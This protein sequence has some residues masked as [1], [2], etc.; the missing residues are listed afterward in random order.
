MTTTTSNTKG[1]AVC[2][3]TAAAAPSPYF[4]GEPGALIPRGKWRYTTTTTAIPSLIVLSQ[5]E[6]VLRISHLRG[7]LLAVIT[8]IKKDGT[9]PHEWILTWSTHHGA[10]DSSGFW[11]RTPGP[12][13]GSF[14]LQFAPRSGEEKKPLADSGE[15]LYLAVDATG[16]LCTSLAPYYWMALDASMSV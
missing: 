10:V 4:V 7:D 15:S 12:Q 16:K 11:R 6:D 14:A 2:L 1:R 9:P 13:E 5:H 8:V 3:R